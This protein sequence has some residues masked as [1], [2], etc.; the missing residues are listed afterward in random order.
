M[1]LTTE[2]APAILHKAQSVACYVRHHDTQK[3]LGGLSMPHSYIILWTGGKQLW[4]PTVESKRELKEEDLHKYMEGQGFFFL[5][6]Q[7]K[8]YGSLKWQ[9]GV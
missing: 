1:R 5:G 4:R 7:Y 8:A 9:K 3:L 2:D 6:F